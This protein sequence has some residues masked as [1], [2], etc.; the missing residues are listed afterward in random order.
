MNPKTTG[1]LFAIAAALGAFVYFYE[2]RG[3]E[4]R[5]QAEEAEKRL[6]PVIEA[7]T[8]ESIT[9][10]AGDSPAVRIERRDGRWQIVAPI[11][12]AADT[13]AADG[14][15]SALA[16]LTS[17]SQVEDP[18]PHEVYGLDAADRNVHFRAGGV[19]RVLR[20]GDNTPLRS[21][22]YAAVDDST[23]VY[24]VR[25]TKVQ[26][27]SKDLDELRDK[28]IAE[29]DTDAVQRVTASWSD[30]RVTIER[31]DEGWRLTSPVQGEADAST[32]DGLLS[33]LSF[34]RATGFVDE[35][36]PEALASFEPAEFAVVIELKAENEGEDHA[37]VSIA[38]GGLS[39]AGTDRFVQAA[40]PSLYTIPAA[41]LEDFPRTLVEYRNRQLAKFGS[42]GANRIEMVFRLDGKTETITGVRGDG[43]WTSSPESFDAA[44]LS[45]LINEL[46]RLRAGD[47][48]ADAMGP[49]ELESVGLE[50][51]TV[52]FSVFGAS[53]DDSEER[54]AEIQLGELRSEGI[55]ARIPGRDTIFLLDADLAE[56]IPLNM[57]AV[58]NR[59]IVEP[60]PVEPDDSSV[61][62]EVYSTPRAE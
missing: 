6:F 25:T 60:E 24:T 7:E 54:L 18:Q 33:G 41:R 4:G 59:F 35:P 27:L 23:A 45:N 34:L 26:S 12:F 36:T 47:I 30:G 19:E 22:S 44:K 16:G 43:G 13:F 55:P 11:D 56:H 58:R 46:S 50:P 38:V 62:A 32:V 5:K 17:E 29:F 49:A 48:L 52:T 40:A 2:I 10:P 39:E 51:A 31:G 21:N 53:G 14:I 37:P 15:A 28:R 20:L 8:I 3:E 9:L 61:E 42:F 1:I 57:E